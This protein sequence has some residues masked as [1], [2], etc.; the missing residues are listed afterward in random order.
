MSVKGISTYS[1][2]LQFSE[3]GGSPYPGS[4]VSYVDGFGVE[5]HFIVYLHAVDEGVKLK[6]NAALSGFGVWCLARSAKH[7][8][9]NPDKAAIRLS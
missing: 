6:I 9:P 3:V 7:Q 5:H 2:S 8:T 4:V 1:V